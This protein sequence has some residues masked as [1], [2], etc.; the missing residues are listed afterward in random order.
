MAQF[1]NK[2]TYG[3]HMSVF[4]LEPTKRDVMGYKLT[5]VAAGVKVPQGYPLKVN[6]ANKTAVVCKYIQIV[7]VA[8]DKKTLTV[9]KNSLAL[10]SEKYAKTG[11]DNTGTLSTISSITYGEEYDTIVLSAANNTIA[12]GDVMVHSS[13]AGTIVNAPNRVAAE[14]AKVDALDATISACHNGIVLKNIVNYP[15]EYLNETTF[16]GSSLLV[17]CPLVMF[18]TQ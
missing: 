15:G 17:G 6:D 16:P 13:A 14:Y 10:A 2:K 11:S 12:A 1:P 4:W 5:N 9:R 7:A 3:G 8:S 18:I